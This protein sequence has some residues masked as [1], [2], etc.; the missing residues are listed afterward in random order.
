MEIKNS[1]NYAKEKLGVDI[2][3]TESKALY[4]IPRLQ[5]DYG[6]L[7]DCAITSIASLIEYYHEGNY[8]EIYNDVEKLAKSKLI[9]NN[10]YGTIPI[11]IDCI[12]KS[13]NNIWNLKLKNDYRY[14]KGIG[15]DFIDIKD[16]INKG[17]P[18]MLSV[19][20]ANE[21]YYKYH[22]VIVKGFIVYKNTKTN[23][24]IKLLIVNDNWSKDNRFIDYDSINKFAVVN[25]YIR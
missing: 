24:E 23:K 14:V 19:L 13:M 7:N 18:I 16:I 25:Y 4:I 12:L 6:D 11:F 8:V 17:H 10:R 3:S 9:Y 22:A 2:I 20:I 15:F 21:G 5:E 1:Y